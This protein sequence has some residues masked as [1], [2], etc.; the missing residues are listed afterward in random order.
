MADLYKQKINET[1]YTYKCI[2]HKDW[3]ELQAKMMIIVP[4][5]QDPN[6]PKEESQSIS[7]DLELYQNNMIC[8]YVLDPK[9]TIEDIDDM[10]ESVHSKLIT[11]IIDKA[12]PKNSQT[13]TVN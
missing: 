5:L 7:D 8:K 10:D 11:L 1:E 3:H 2:C 13:G 12:T 6:T 4:Q 9:I